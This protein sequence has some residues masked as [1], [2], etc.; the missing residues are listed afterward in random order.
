MEKPPGE[1]YKRSTANKKDAENLDGEEDAGNPSGDPGSGQDMETPAGSGEMEN[2]AINEDMGAMSGRG[3]KQRQGSENDSGIPAGPGDRDQP[4]GQEDTKRPADE[5]DTTNLELDHVDTEG[6]ESPRPSD[7]TSS[8]DVE[9]PAVDTDV[10]S[11]AVEGKREASIDEGGT[12]C[13]STM[14]DMASLEEKEEEEEDTLSTVSDLAGDWDNDDP[15]A[16]DYSAEL[17]RRYIR[18]YLVMTIHHVF[19]TTGALRFLPAVIAAKHITRLVNVTQAIFI[20]PEGCGPRIRMYKPVA[21]GV[22]RQ[23][24]T[25]FGK[26]MTKSMLLL[27]DM[28]VEEY[29]A[30]SVYVQ[31]CTVLEQKQSCVIPKWVK[32]FFMVMVGL[33]PVTLG[34]AAAIVLVL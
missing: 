16:D 10:E 31:T 2:L 23:L 30:R 24:R 4:A 28:S 5:T 12:E 13:T 20:L 27:A 11:S 14:F 8:G 26:P 6:T 34:A 15:N 9:C 33:I 19:L 32:K 22:V 25:T 17:R 21:R 18:L 29:I 3:Y 1:G 7:A